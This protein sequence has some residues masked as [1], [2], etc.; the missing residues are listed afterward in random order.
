MSVRRRSGWLRG[1]RGGL[2]RPKGPC[3]HSAASE[4]P[5]ESVAGRLSEVA[6]TLDLRLRRDSRCGHQRFR[7]RLGRSE[8]MR[9]CD[10]SKERMLRKR[11]ERDE[12]G[13]RV[14]NGVNDGRQ[15]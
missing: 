3:L 10:A 13:N 15:G 2:G 11:E 4:A 9:K 14:E 6:D 12:R 1:S 5:S 7:R 8:W